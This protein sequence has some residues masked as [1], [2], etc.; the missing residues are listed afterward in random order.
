MEE[1]VTDDELNFCFATELQ[2]ARN[3]NYKKILAK[4]MPVD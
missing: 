3:I 4:V 2:I 1:S